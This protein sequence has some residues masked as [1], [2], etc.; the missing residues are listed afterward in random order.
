M[1]HRRGAGW[2]RK[3]TPSTRKDCPSCGS[4]QARRSVSTVGK[5]WTMTRHIDDEPHSAVTKQIVAHVSEYWLMPGV[6]TDA[7]GRRGKR[8]SRHGP[9]QMRCC[10]GWRGCS[11]AA[12]ARGA[13]T[14]SVVLL[15]PGSIK[16]A[17][18]KL[19]LQYERTAAT[20]AVPCG[21]SRAETTWTL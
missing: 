1:S 4:V 8:C 11:Y 21:R 14:G 6:R 3:Q 5:P 15:S 13:P 2:R 9:G 20:C 18:L 10:N 17:T 16:H 19:L 12:T 7:D